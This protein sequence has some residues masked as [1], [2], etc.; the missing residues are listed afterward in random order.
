V[1]EFPGPSFSV[2]DTSPEKLSK[3]F[4]LGFRGSNFALRAGMV[5]SISPTLLANDGEDTM[6][7]GTTIVVTENGFKELGERKLE[8]SLC[9]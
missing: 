3:T 9:A 5:Y 6:L 4:G 1:P 8:L 2:P 7:A